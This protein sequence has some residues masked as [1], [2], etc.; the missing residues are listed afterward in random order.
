MT[1][2]R[3][4]LL[5]RSPEHENGGEAYGPV[6]QTPKGVISVVQTIISDSRDGEGDIRMC[7]ELVWSHTF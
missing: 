2:G 5:E 3:H 4:A 1:E 6:E 7:T